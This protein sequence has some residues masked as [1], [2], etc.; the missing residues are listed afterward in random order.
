ML[1][2]AFGR[3]D[4]QALQV[5]MDIKAAAKPQTESDASSDEEVGGVAAGARGKRSLVAAIR[6]RVCSVHL[7]PCPPPGQRLARSSSLQ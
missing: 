7:T 4:D 6:R 1:W 3:L 5:V 2:A